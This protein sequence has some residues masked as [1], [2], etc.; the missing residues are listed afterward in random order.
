MSAIRMHGHDSLDQVRFAIM[1]VNGSVG[2]VPRKTR[3]NKGE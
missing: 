2:V 1:E 3:D